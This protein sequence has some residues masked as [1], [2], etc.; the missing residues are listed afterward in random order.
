M[1]L[2][3]LA[4]KLHKWLALIVGVQLMLWTASGL[5]MTIFP[6]AEVRGEHLVNEV[7][8]LK[9]DRPFIMPDFDREPVTGLAL[10]MIGER[11]VLV[12]DHP[13]RRMMHDPY[14]GDMIPPPDATGITELASQIY[15]GEDRIEAIELIERDPPSEW[16]GPLPVWQVRYDGAD[17]LRLYFDAD[18]GELL[19]R[20]TRLWRVYDF[21]WMLHIMDYDSREDFNNPLVQAAAGLGLSVALSGL[22]LVVYRTLKPWFARRRRVKAR[23]AAI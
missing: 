10:R 11:P 23:K 12:V 2:H 18:T 17:R 7:P 14:T 20:R 9:L 6:I 19:T 21:M 5:F 3:P 15:A 22:L 1:K 8:D 13:T 16:R 4:S